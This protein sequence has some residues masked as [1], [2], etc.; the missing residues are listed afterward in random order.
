MKVLVANKFLFRNGGSEAVMLAEREFL[1]ASGVEVV[2]FAMHDDRNPPSPYASWFVANQRYGEGGSAAE[3]LK[4]ALKLIHSPE[5]V[6]KIGALI[7]ATRPDLVHCHNIYHQLTPS[8]IGAARRRGVPVVLTLHDYKPVCPTYL[9]LRHGA[10][11]SAC[12]DGGPFNVVRHRCADGS[13]ARSALLYAEAV[14]QRLLRSYEQVD[15]FIAPSEFMRAAVTRRFPPERVRLLYNGVDTRAITP[16][17]GDAGYVL[18][19]GRLSAE[20]GIETLLEAHEGIADRVPLRIAGTGPLEAPLRARYPRAQ[21]LGHLSG[22]AI[23]EAIRGAA[24]IAVPS[25][26]YENCPISVLEAMAHGKPVVASAIGGIPELVVHE[27]TGLLFPPGDGRALADCL[28][29]L[30]ADASLRR[31]FGRA[32]RARVERRFSLEG[33]NAALLGTYKEVLE[34]RRQG[35]TQVDIECS[36]TSTLLE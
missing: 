35:Q 33:H 30:M 29:R 16:A 17:D 10:P 9:R 28:M 14:V 36:S 22:A 34:S 6:R 21:F 12:L 5:A 31:R 11:C 15:T 2:D 20:K 13:L 3:R 1:R 7:D 26:W 8:I 23:D 19:L 25:R 27:E 24:L 32:G 4:T 18:Y